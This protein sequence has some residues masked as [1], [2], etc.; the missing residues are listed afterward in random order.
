MEATEYSMLI[1]GQLVESDSYFEVINPATKSV[2]AKVPD[3]SEAQLDEAVK[4]ARS[5]FPSW[6][7]LGY[8]ERRKLLLKLADALEAQ[9]PE[10]IAL[11]SKEQGKPVKGFAG[12]GAGFEFGGTLAW[13]RGTCEYELKPEL[14]QENDQVNSY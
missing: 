9:A 4:A 11:L 5:A 1:N 13:I 14:V 7:A 6:S 8:P 10:I 3:A 12:M 2:I